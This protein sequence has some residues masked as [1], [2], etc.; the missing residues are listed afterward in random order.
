MPYP[1]RAEGF[2]NMISSYLL[3]TVKWFHRFLFDTNT[4]LNE[5]KN[6]KTIIFQTIQI[7]IVF[8]FTQSFLN[9]IFFAYTQLND[10]TVLFQTI[11]LIISMHFKCQTVIRC[12]HSGLVWSWERWQWRGTLHSRKLHHNWSQNFRSFSVISRELV[13]RVLPLCWDAVSVF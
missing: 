13:G 10:Q 5:K 1:V 6:K 12:Y 11:H 7:S 4:L 3:H 8:V 9:T 2:A